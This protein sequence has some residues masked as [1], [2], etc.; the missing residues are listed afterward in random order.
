ME[1]DVGI[2][3]VEVITLKIPVLSLELSD[4]GFL[5]F[6]GLNQFSNPFQQGFVLL[7]ELV[8]Q[9]FVLLQNKRNQNISMPGSN[10]ARIKIPPCLGASKLFKG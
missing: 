9:Y 8:V 10:D 5:H 6:S 3:S 1:S 2:G 7:V 4:P